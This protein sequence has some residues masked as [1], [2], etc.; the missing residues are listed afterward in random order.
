MRILAIIV[1]VIANTFSIGQSLNHFTPSQIKQLDS[2]SIQDVPKG[3]PGIATGIVSNGKIVYQKVAGFANLTDSSLITK[4]TRFNIASNG[5]QF[6][7]FYFSLK[8]LLP[9]KLVCQC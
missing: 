4:D 2:I 7:A 8:N 3:A 1:F 5:K 6:T 9:L